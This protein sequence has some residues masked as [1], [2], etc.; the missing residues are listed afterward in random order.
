MTLSEEYESIEKG[1]G[2]ALLSDSVL[3]FE[4]KDALKF[5]QGILSNDLRLLKAKQGLGSFFLTAKGRWIAALKLFQI[6]S[7]IFAQ[8]SLLES[9]ALQE[10]IRAL[11]LF[12]DTQLEDLSSQY[13]WILGIGNRAPKFFQEVFAFPLSSPPYYHQQGNLD[14]IPFEIIQ[15]EGWSFSTFLLLVL[16][17]DA[18]NLIER[19]LALKKDYPLRKISERSLEALRIESKIPKFGQDV[20]EKTIPLEAN[21]DSYFSYTK[22]CYVGQETI[23]RIK[24]YGHVSKKLVKLR[25][26]EKRNI[27]L[28]S[29][30]FFQDKEVG[31]ITSC[32]DSLGEDA[33]LA[34]T[35]LPRES[36]IAGL[37]VF[38]ELKDQKEEAQ[39]IP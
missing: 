38:I 18:E 32:C 29:R 13:N 22:G 24:H 36:A 20:D 17:K 26:K 6:Q 21:F 19:L 33:T 2:F 15:N 37:Q 16:R 4:G 28:G 5:L 35:T 31:K 10:A 27:P 1:L 12:S 8:T 34:L 30:V 11:I 9:K 25:L 7:S 14:G 23:S 3:R 39:V